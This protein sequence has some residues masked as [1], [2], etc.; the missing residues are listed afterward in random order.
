MKIW[1][2][3]IGLLALLALTGCAYS[4]KAKDCK[5]ISLEG[6]ETKDSKCTYDPWE[7]WY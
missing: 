4:I 7:K 6:V 3:A 5:K 2:T 1:I